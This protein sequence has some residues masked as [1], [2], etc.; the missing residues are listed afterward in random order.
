MSAH[1][2]FSLAHAQHGLNAFTFFFYALIFSMFLNNLMVK[3]PITKKIKNNIFE[4]ITYY[5]YL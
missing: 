4:E 1:S 2:L 3:S 5:R